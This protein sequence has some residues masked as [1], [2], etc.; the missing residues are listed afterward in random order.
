MVDGIRPKI[1][2]VTRDTDIVG[3]PPQMPQNIEIRGGD[4]PEFTHDQSP[5]MLLIRE[6]SG[7]DKI[8]DKLPQVISSGPIY[9]GISKQIT[10][11]QYK[12]I[13]RRDHIKRVIRDYVI[14]AIVFVLFL[15]ALVFLT[16]YKEL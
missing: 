4:I 2:I 8:T 7:E 1:T 11:R 3:V 16:V 6:M 12:A 10:V 13:I 9:R 5:L 15:A 14:P